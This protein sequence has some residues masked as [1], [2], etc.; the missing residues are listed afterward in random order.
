MK[1]PFEVQNE[2]QNTELTYQHVLGDVIFLHLTLA[3]YTVGM[4]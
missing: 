2:I 1:L 4:T 3:M